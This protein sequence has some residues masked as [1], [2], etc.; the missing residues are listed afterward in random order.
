[1]HNANHNAAHN[2]YDINKPSSGIL[3]VS[4]KMDQNEIC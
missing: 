1:M 2:V 3:M 4:N